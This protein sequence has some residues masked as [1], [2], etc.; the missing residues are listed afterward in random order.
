MPFPNEIFDFIVGISILHHLDLNLALKEISRVLKPKGKFVFSEPNM[1]NPQIF[2]QKRI[3]FL[4]KL[5]GDSPFETAF[6]AF[7]A[8]K[9]F[10]K[11]DLKA[12]ITPFDF[13]HPK[14]PAF[15]IPFIAKLGLRLEKHAILKNIS[16]SL[17]M[18]G[19]KI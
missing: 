9:T 11:Y 12:Q 16:G 14:T 19:E 13:L 18:R 2:V 7:K 15:L 10:L 6:S 5:L 1:L 3:S 8:K 17:I 4:K